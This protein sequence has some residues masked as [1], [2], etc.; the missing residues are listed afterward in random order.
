MVVLKPQDL[1]LRFD[2]LW[3]FQGLWG[4][5]GLCDGDNYQKPFYSYQHVLQ[6]LSFH[7]DIASSGPALLIYTT[8][9]HCGQ[10]CKMQIP[11]GEGM[12]EGFYFLVLQWVWKYIVAFVKDFVTGCFVT[13]Q[14]GFSNSF[15]VQRC[16]PSCPDRQISLRFALAVSEPA[17]VAFVCTMEI[18]PPFLWHVRTERVPHVGVLMCGQ[19]VPGLCPQVMLLGA[20]VPGLRAPSLCPSLLQWSNSASCWLLRLACHPLASFWAQCCRKH[21]SVPSA[22][23]LAT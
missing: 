1:N 13:P 22:D 10:C 3:L 16:F 6:D 20:S 4:T 17:R 12:E 9:H 21:T 8:C 19:R 18:F 2:V 5:E 15:S 7:C 14:S 23:R 11:G